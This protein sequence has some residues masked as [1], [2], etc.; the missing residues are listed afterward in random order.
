[1][2][3]RE[4]PLFAAS[5][6]GQVLPPYEV[7]PVMTPTHFATALRAHVHGL[8]CMEAA[9]ELLVAQS[10]LHR[11]DFTSE[12]MSLTRSLV[13]DQPLAVVDWAS[14]ITALDTGDLPCSRGE[15]RMLRMTASIADG[16]PVDLRDSLTGLDE[17][18][19]QLLLRAVLHTS[20]RH[21]ST[22]VP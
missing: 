19:T 17:H 3:R 9:A 8:Y 2:L 1:M 18:N 11:T 22:P 5:V 21:P 7:L 10:W 14:A 15:Q 6:A 20:G 12:F 13:D 4:W 16:I